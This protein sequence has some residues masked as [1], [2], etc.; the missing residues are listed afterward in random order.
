[1]SFLDSLMG[2]GQESGSGL[3]DVVGALISKAGG[4]QGLVGQLQQSGLGQQVGS[5]VS[6]GA[7]LPVSAEQL[8]AALQSGPL[9][10]VLQQATQKLGMDSP[11]LLQQLSGLLPQ[12]VDKLTPEGQ[13]PQGGVD[14]GALTGLAAR[15]FGH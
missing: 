4:L 2:Q 1:M 9:A 12:A 7:N 3:M 8:G 5:W 13:V 15:L 11:Q 6:T 10:G 14:L